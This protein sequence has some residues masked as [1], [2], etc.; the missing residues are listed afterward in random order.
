MN[1]DQRTTPSRRRLLARATAVLVA[2]IAAR[3]PALA[4]GSATTPTST[5]TTATKSAAWA[6]GMELAVNVEIDLPQG[7]RVQRPYVAAWIEDASG[8]P[9]RTLALWAN[10]GGRGLRY[11]PDLRRW[12]R[13]YQTNDGIIDTVSGPTRNPGRYSLVWDG[14]DDRKALVPQGQYYVVVETAREHGP[15]SLIRESVTVGAKPFTRDLGAS[16]DVKGVSVEFRRKS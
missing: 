11:L 12:F 13:E 2:M 14:R 7:F 16:D 8:R 9:V 10:T 1:H 4:Q 15:Y 5:T 6:S 3:L